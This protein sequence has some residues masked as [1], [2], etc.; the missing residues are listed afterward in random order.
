MSDKQKK[1]I[2]L[3]I[4]GVLIIIIV[5]A[6]ATRMAPPSGPGQSSVETQVLKTDCEAIIIQ[7]EENLKKAKKR[8]LPNNK[9]T[10]NE[11]KKDAVFQ[12]SDNRCGQFP[13]IKSRL[14][15]FIGECNDAL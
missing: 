1:V 11:L 7:Y 5:Y 15:T 2:V 3:S 9:E 12:L 6:F 14:K 4:I 10:I 13:A 8:I